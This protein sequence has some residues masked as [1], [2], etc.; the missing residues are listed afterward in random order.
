MTQRTHRLRTA[1]RQLHRVRLSPD[2]LRRQA[3]KQAD[4]L[5]LLKQNKLWKRYADHFRTPGGRTDE[6]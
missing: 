2:E 3:H 1:A 4:R 6:G 5:W